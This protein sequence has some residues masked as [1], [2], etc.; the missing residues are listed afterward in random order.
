M[1]NQPL[2]IN[3][4]IKLREKDWKRLQDLLGKSR[5]RS[6]LS[7]AEVRELSDLYRAVTSDLA[8]AQRDYARQRVTAFLNQLTARAHSVIYQEDVSDP[9]QFLRF[10]THTIPQT[11]RQT[12]LFT[13]AAFLLFIIPAAISF[14]VAF[15]DPDALARAL[16]MT[17]LQ[18]TLA[19]SD[20][21]TEI[22]VEDRPASSAFIMS[23]NIRI[24]ILAFG[25]GISFGI[26][27]VY[28][29]IFNGV[30]IGG[31]L[32][33]AYHYGMGDELLAFI[34]GHGVIELSII[35]IAGGAGL[36]LG[37]ALLNPGLYSRRDALVL[38]AR[39]ALALAV[40]AIPFLIIAG[41]IEG[42]VSPSD[43][44]TPFWLRLM[45][46][47]VSGGLMYAYLLLSGRDR[48]AARSVP[49]LSPGKEAHMG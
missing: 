3:D 34:V 45:V 26:V 38:A 35:F 20:I 6:S 47:L 10:I 21:W 8:L 4:F 36:Q 23:N 25:A 9:R 31:V 39:R 17:D 32:G 37:W 16:G 43:I 41:L 5:G 18:Q 11:F 7:A 49:G 29:L 22:P 27:T 2:N 44:P 40:L 19:D 30:F 24:A 42:F 1:L 15:T 33:M 14:R 12:W 28:L 48:T 46:G 13:L